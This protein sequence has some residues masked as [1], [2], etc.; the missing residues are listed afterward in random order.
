MNRTVVIISNN[1][2]TMSITEILYII[3]KYFFDVYKI[4]DILLD[5]RVQ[6]VIYK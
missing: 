6:T 3:F 4:I 2:W 5:I 1:C